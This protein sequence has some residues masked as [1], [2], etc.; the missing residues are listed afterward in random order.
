MDCEATEE[1]KLPFSEATPSS[2]T[3][4][5][6]AAWRKIMQYWNIAHPLVRWDAAYAYRKKAINPKN[7]APL[8]ETR[9]WKYYAVRTLQCVWNCK[10]RQIIL[11]WSVTMKHF[12]I[13][14]QTPTKTTSM[15]STA[16]T[17]CFQNHTNREGHPA[18]QSLMTQLLQQSHPTRLVHWVIKY[19]L[20][21]SYLV[22][23]RPSSSH[24]SGACQ[25]SCPSNSSLW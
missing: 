13:S 9:C 18:T 24:L 5:A 2:Q 12:T 1:E 3:E 23:R 21:H 22:T 11:S 8:S 25:K 14:A 10:S 7:T 15:E 4:I 6:K 20:V 17:T 16:R 19:E